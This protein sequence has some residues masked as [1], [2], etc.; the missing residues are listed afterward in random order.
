MARE[1]ALWKRLRDAG[2]ALRQTGHL[3]DLQ[4]LENAAGVGHPDVE[5]C[6]DGGQ[7]WIEL[8]SE[9]RPVRVTTAIHPKKRE[10]QNIWHRVRSEAGCRIN[11]ILLQVGEAHGARLY[12]IPGHCYDKIEATEAEIERLSVV[13]PNA[14]PSDCLLRA[15]RGW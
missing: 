13:P 11:W 10:S 1:S 3:V 7:V 15:T 6:I 14:S 12:L 2:V 8:K 9:L 5:G 4:R